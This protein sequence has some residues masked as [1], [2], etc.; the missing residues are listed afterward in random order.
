MNKNMN[1]VAKVEAMMPDLVARKL[2]ELLV[3]DACYLDVPGRQALLRLMPRLVHVRR[4][5]KA[6]FLRYGCGNCHQKR[7]RYGAGGLC[8]ACAVRDY[9]RMKAEIHKRLDGRDA[10]EETAAL[11][12][13]LD[14]AQFLLNGDD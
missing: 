13:K 10:K 9:N 2:D 3:F 8:N 4:A 11:T 5:R 1:K 14:M 12:R 6:I 7:V